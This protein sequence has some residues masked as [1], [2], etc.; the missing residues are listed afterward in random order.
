MENGS[1]PHKSDKHDFRE[2]WGFSPGISGKPNRFSEK[3][4]GFPG[5]INFLLQ[6]PGASSILWET[7]LENDLKTRMLRPENS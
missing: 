2:E 6:L 1:F 5:S 3:M 7:I 4:N